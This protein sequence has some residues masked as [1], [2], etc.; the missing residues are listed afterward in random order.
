LKT[1]GSHGMLEYNLEGTKSGPTYDVR[2]NYQVIDNDLRAKYSSQ[3]I[4]SKSGRI[5][6]ISQRN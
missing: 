3:V 4:D 1:A 6:Q 5:I 2:A